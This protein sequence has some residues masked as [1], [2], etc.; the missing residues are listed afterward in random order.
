MACGKPCRMGGRP[1]YN[2]QAWR[3]GKNGARYVLKGEAE[4]L[5]KDIAGYRQ[6]HSCPE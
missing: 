1:H 6:F 2:H 3:N 4:D 5:E